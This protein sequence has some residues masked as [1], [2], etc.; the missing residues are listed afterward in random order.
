MFNNQFGTARAVKMRWH[1]MQMRIMSTSVCE[2][3]A[4]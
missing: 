2:A 4:V 1:G 3:G